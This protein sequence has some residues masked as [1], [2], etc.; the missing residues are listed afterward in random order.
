MV[1]GSLPL[2]LAMLHNGLA[3]CLFAALVLLI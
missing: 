3:A 1:H 2:G